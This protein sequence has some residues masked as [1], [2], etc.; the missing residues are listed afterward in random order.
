MVD[1][2]RMKERRA[3]FEYY[4]SSLNADAVEKYTAVLERVIEDGKS[5]PVLAAAD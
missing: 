3:A 1:E 5:A 4:V 2:A